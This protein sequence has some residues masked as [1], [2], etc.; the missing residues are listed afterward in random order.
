MCGDRGLKIFLFF[1]KIYRTTSVQNVCVYDDALQLDM[2]NVSMANDVFTGSREMFWCDLK[3]H[4]V[5]FSYLK[6]RLL[7]DFFL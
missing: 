6:P 5:K 4:H 2:R 1:Y 7:T 3:F